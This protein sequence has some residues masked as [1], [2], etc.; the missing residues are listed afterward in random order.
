MSEKEYSKDIN[1]LAKYFVST[2]NSEKGKSDFLLFV[3]SGFSNNF[4]L[5]TWDAL[6]RQALYY[7]NEQGKK[8]KLSEIARL[9]EKN[10]SGLE[11]ISYVASEIGEDDI[12]KIIVKNLTVEKDKELFSDNKNKV[13]HIIE[14]IKKNNLSVITTNADNLFKLLLPDWKQQPVN[15]E[16][17]TK[18]MAKQIPFPDKTVFYIHGHSADYKSLVFTY[19]DYV[20]AYKLNGMR[21]F[22]ESAFSKHIIFI[23][24]SL[25]DVELLDIF[26]T[27]HERHDAYAFQGIYKYQEVDYN[28]AKIRND[29]YSINTVKYYL[30]DNSYG[31]LD[32][33]FELLQTKIEQF[34]ERLKKGLPLEDITADQLTEALKD[35]NLTSNEKVSKSKEFLET[36]EGK[37][38]FEKWIH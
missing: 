5:P 33:I 30:D 37:E 28:L 8:L 35:E 20:K 13:Q 12:K 11:L 32:L 7:S 9:K 36:N 34:S 17:L 25:S 19:K 1:D 14:F 21:N 15:E 10:C 4:Q 23:G 27:V 16:Y 3:G 22:M 31:E 6:G 18:F 38:M 29:A 24:Y 2:Q 26:E